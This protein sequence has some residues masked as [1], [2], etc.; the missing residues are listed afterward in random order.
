MSSLRLPY[1]TLSP[2]PYRAF[3]AAGTALEQSSLGKKLV[4][5]LFLRISQINGCAF[6]VDKHAHDLMA[7][8]EDF[9]RINSLS[10][11]RETDFY[12]SRERAALAWAEAVTRLDDGHVPDHVFL[13]LKE[14]F[15]DEE[16]ADLGFTSALMNAW[17]RM[18]I[19]FRQPVTRTAA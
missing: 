16:I 19:G 2:A 7:A 8:G 12:S 10:T 15:T 5:L 3:I 18:A 11:W 17:N 6:C 9:Q 13:P 4:H 1:H 14:Q